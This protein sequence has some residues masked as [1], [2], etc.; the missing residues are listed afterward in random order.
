MVREYI[1][2]EYTSVLSSDLG[3][4]NFHVLTTAVALVDVLATRN[5]WNHY[6]PYL[7]QFLE[8]ILEP[9]ELEYIRMFVKTY[10]IV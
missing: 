10:I 3:A 5:Y 6:V 1:E 2:S 8:P 4:L 7:F 9:D